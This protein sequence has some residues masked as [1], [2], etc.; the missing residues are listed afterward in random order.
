MS[1]L[2]GWMRKKRKKRKKKKGNKKTERETGRIR[3]SE[4]MA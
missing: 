3:E 2:K 1:V 4:P